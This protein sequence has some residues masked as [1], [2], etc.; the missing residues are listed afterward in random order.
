VFE[1][2]LINKKPKE[3]IADI[4][5][6]FI[7][8]AH[9]AASIAMVLERAKIFMVSDLPDDLV[10]SIHLMPF[11]SLQEAVDEAIRQMGENSK[12]LVLPEAGSV[13]PALI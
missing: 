5:D 6:R 8:G 4:K 10:R 9:K 7:L 2:W 12:V 3:I 13:M 1:E 11:A